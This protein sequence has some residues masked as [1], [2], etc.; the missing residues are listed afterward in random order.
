[1]VDSLGP[2]QYEISI[3]GVNYMHLQH[4]ERCFIENA[5]ICVFYMDTLCHTKV[6]GMGL[7]L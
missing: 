1:M 5:R 4:I 3:S 2:F 6:Q 7:Q